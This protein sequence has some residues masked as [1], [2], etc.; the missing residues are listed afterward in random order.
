MLPMAANTRVGPYTPVLPP[1]SL[2]PVFR[3]TK[4]SI[5]LIS[6]RIPFDIPEKSVAGDVAAHRV[7]IRTSPAS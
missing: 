1:G 7:R 2:F 5:F 4:V 3:L 6:A